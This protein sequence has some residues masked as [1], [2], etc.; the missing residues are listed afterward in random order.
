[1]IASATI[2]LFLPEK[3][4][5]LILLIIVGFGYPV[6]IVAYLYYWVRSKDNNQIYQERKFTFFDDYMMVETQNGAK[7]EFPYSEIHNVI[8]RKNVFLIYISKTQF[9]Y[10]P[11]NVFKSD[12]DF[13]GFIQKIKR[14]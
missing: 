14:I 4:K 1:M 5:V 12:I 8:E 7:T 3:D 10:I 6:F 11:K 9:F 13:E 2:G